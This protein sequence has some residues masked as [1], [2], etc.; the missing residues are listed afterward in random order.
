MSKRFVRQEAN[1]YSKIGKNVKKRQKWR[2]PTGRDSK[3]RLKRK[4]YPA[5]VKVGYKTAKKELGKIQGMKPVLIH[6]LHELN[7]LGKG[8][9]AILARIGAKKKLEI[10][11]HAQDKKIKI[12]NVKGEKQ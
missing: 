5:T 9:V 3:M 6:N 11:K 7:N 12:L 10:I 4:S 8:S 2:R 1:T